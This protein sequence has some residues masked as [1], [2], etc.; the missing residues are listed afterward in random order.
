M[1]AIAPGPHHVHKAYIMFKA[2]E[3]LRQLLVPI[4]VSLF[5]LLNL[6]D[7]SLPV[8]VL[9][10]LVVAVFVAIDV[11]VSVVSYQRFTWE[12]T[13]SELHIKK[14]IFNKK[15]EHIPFMRV[16]AVNATA[17]VLERLLG[18]VTLTVDTA[19]GS[20]GGGHI[21]ALTLGEYEA[22]RSEMFDRKRRL[23]GEGAMG[24]APVLPATRSAQLE[25]HVAQFEGTADEGV[26]GGMAKGLS[27][28]RTEMDG[29]SGSLRGMFGGDF[30]DDAAIGFERTLTGKQLLLK[31]LSGSNVLLPLLITMGFIS[32]FSRY[33]PDSVKQ[34]AADA[35]EL[36]GAQLLA[37]GAVLI[38]LTLMLVL[39]VS[40]VFGVISS[41]LT[42]GGFVVRRRGGRIEVERGLLSRYSSGV[43]V[44]R[45]Q[46]VRI[47]QGFLSRLI[48]YAEVS[49]VTASE[50]NH[51]ADAV[52]GSLVVHPFIRRKEARAFVDELLPGYDAAP[53]RLGGLPPVAVRRSFNRFA[54][55][56]GLVLAL[57]AAGASLLLP[58]STVPVDVRL[59]RAIV[60]LALVVCLA[61]AVAYAVLWYR[62]AGF[63]H[64]AGFVVLQH[65]GWGVTRTIAPRSR[66]QW[67]RTSETPFQERVKVA[68]IKIALLASP[69]GVRVSL[70]DLPVEQA[71]VILDWARPRALDGSAA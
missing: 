39:L 22:L 35:V 57:V 30:T 41:T 71:K 37:A 62:H 38:V 61:M 43:S 21:K 52:A 24:S 31:G 25:R 48:G 19:S 14:G 33:L 26:G 5:P 3:N 18:L 12:L 45:V 40:W 6:N 68:T 49:L 58:A 55:W 60:G 36:A 17:N 11:T 8:P 9:I 16:Y 2:I 4:V 34:Q 20:Q 50:G 29:S 69:P 32:Q 53:E 54:L 13:S 46:A 7:S 23:V 64:N 70:R 42:Y 65:G 51:R 44:V 47:H 1:S 56:P 27:R 28:A 10:A 67:V 59:G 63:A 15:H 66:I